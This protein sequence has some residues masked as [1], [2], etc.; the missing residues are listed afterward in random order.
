VC[1]CGNAA[2][3]LRVLGCSTV[4]EWQGRDAVYGGSRSAAARGIDPRGRRGAGGEVIA[5]EVIGA[6]LP[7]V[8]TAV[9]SV[10]V[11]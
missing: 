1:A 2:H 4:S 10:S 7:M 5:R 8:V 6:V 11:G 9:S 3:A